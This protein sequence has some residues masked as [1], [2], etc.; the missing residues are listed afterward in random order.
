MAELDSRDFAQK[1]TWMMGQAV[2]LL[3]CCCMRAA[4][5]CAVCLVEPRLGV[6]AAAAAAAAPR[7]RRPLGAGERAV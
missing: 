2:Y 5:C 6:E 4:A 7:P 3:A 1:Q